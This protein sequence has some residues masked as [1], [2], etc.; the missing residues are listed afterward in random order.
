M[1]LFRKAEPAKPPSSRIFDRPWRIEGDRLMDDADHV[2]A[3]DRRMERLLSQAWDAET[4]AVLRLGLDHE[5]AAK[6]R[7]VNSSD[8][9]VIKGLRRRGIARPLTIPPLAPGAP[10]KWEPEIEES[11]AAPAPSEIDRA[12]GRAFRLLAD[13]LDPQ[14]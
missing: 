3:A 11:A 8:W 13:I 7:G 4:E 1:N 14:S 10:V 9:S 12:L 2:L 6:A 5:H